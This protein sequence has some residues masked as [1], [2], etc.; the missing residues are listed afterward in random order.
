MIIKVNNYVLVPGRFVAGTR[1]SYGIEPIDFEFSKEWEGLAVSVSFYPPVG[2]PVALIYTGEPFYIPPEVMNKSGTSKFV[3]SGYKDDKALITAEGL[4]RVLETSVPTQNPALIPT[5]SQ[6]AQIMTALE[7]KV[8]AVTGM[9]LSSNDYTDAEK[10]KLAGIESGAQVNVQPDWAQTDSSACDYIKNKPVLDSVPTACS[11]RGVTSGGVYAALAGKADTAHNHSSTYAPVGHNH[12]ARYAPA[13]HSH[14]TRYAPTSGECAGLVSGFAKNLSPARRV[15]TSGI[16]SKRRSAGGERDCELAS[17]R[18]KSISGMSMVQLLENGFTGLEGWEVSG[19]AALAGNNICSLAPYIPEKPQGVEADISLEVG[20]TFELDDY[21]IFIQTCAA[22]D[23]GIIEVTELDSGEGWQ[24]RGLAPGRTT[25]RVYDDPFYENE[26]DS[27][28][29]KVVEEVS[30]PA[31]PPEMSRNINFIS[32]HRYYITA[33]IKSPAPAP[34]ITLFAGYEG[35]EQEMGCDDSGDWQRVSG[36]FDASETCAARVGMRDRRRITAS[37]SYTGAVSWASVDAEAFSRRIKAF[38]PEAS[39]DYTFVYNSGWYPAGGSAVV[40]VASFGIIPAWIAGSTEASRQGSTITV[41]FS[42]PYNKEASASFAVSGQTGLSDVSVN[43]AEFAG[44]LGSSAKRGDYVFTYVSGIGWTFEDGTKVQLSDYGITGLASGSPA[45]GAKITVSLELSGDVIM[46][47]GF[48]VY[49]LTQLGMEDFTA[50]E[51]D[52]LLG[53]KYHEPGLHNAIVGGI[54]SSGSTADAFESELHFSQAYELCRLPDGASDL[55]DFENQILCRKVASQ[56]VSGPAGGR[57]SLAGAKPGTAYLCAEGDIGSVEGNILTLSR[58]VSSLCVYYERAEAEIIGISEPDS[59]RVATGG[60]EELVAYDSDA[61]EYRPAPL[62]V[63]AIV[64]YIP[65][66]AR[67]VEADRVRLLGLLAAI[68]VHSSDDP[69][70]TAA[71][72]E[73]S[74]ALEAFITAHASA[75]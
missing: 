1:G 14:D 44:A 34:G 60:E 8:D 33:R 40:S 24:L 19:G 41:R 35:D 61:G 50:A 9:G 5:P 58:E 23:P 12:D 20:Q 37:I 62:G 49:D 26:L 31:G 71:A 25:V 75:P 17:A 47:S 36:I 27:Y 55:L 13:E 66:Y 53:E 45:N 46:A 28:T 54:K 6:F 70:V 43:A 29:V 51:L 72:A 22:D 56:T 3:V 42:Y 68:G 67:Q 74:A 65:D 11:D 73:I 4:I 59:Y 64:E 52:M 63:P 10:S 69:A 18:V 7:G 16:F 39:G 32:G 57:V 2:D 21:D 30:A 15:V 38:S 48:A